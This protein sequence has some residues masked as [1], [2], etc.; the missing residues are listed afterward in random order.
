[1]EFKKQSDELKKQLDSRIDKY[2]GRAVDNTFDIENVYPEIMLVS[3]FSFTMFSMTRDLVA[4]M[5]SG[6]MNFD[7][8]FNSAK[9]QN[10][11]DDPEQEISRGNII[12]KSRTSY[13][14]LLLE[15]RAINN[16]LLSFKAENPTVGL[17]TNPDIVHRFF[18]IAMEKGRINQDS[19]NYEKISKMLVSDPDATR[20]KAGRR[21]MTEYVESELGKRELAIT[22]GKVNVKDNPGDFFKT[23]GYIADNS[24]NPDLAYAFIAEQLSQ[25]PERLTRKTNN[26]TNSSPSSNSTVGLEANAT[27]VLPSP[28]LS[29]ILP[30]NNSIGRQQ[31]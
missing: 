3:A 11:Q 6:R 9:E 24:R 26:Q 19:P 22:T 30:E 17:P 28:K 15:L 27:E 5:L 21:Y 12:A 31:K 16:A 13:D 18:Q 23:L 20:S 4:P 14:P 7:T 2:I 1:M 29:S 10:F 8:G 25:I